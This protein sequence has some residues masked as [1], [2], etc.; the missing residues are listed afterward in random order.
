M[1]FSLFPKTIKFFELFKKQNQKLLE[2]SNVLKQIFLDFDQLAE[3]RKTIDQIEKDANDIFHLISRELAA[4]F[5]TPIDREDIYAINVTQEEVINLIKA[6]TTRISLY[7]VGKIRPAA[8]DLIEN[9]D[10]MITDI[11]GMI[12][13]LDSKKPSIEICK[14]VRNTK[15]ESDHILLV[16][17]GELY[18][19]HTAETT[20]ILD[21]V[22][23]TQIYDRIE[24]TIQKTENL[25]NI[26]EGI[27]IKNA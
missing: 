5:I 25:A 18:E 7:E 17:I 22:K 6:I 26:V 27:S 1:S 20:P 3:K 10:S 12:N 23:W 15:E 2:A 16:A 8:T 4:T 9:V 21:I 13:L 19:A 11:A 14:K 24:Q